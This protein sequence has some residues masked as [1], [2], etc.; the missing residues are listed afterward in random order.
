MLQSYGPFVAYRGHYAKGVEDGTFLLVLL[1]WCS[2][3][4][5]VL[6]SAYLL[7]VVADA[8]MLAGVA[9]GW[10]IFLP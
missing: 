4:R 8:A 10:T 6:A 3:F 7:S 2:D 1:G 9:V 5:S